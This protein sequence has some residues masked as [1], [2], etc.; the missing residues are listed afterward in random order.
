MERDL[1]TLAAEGRRLGSRRPRVYSEAWPNPRISSPPWVSELIALLGG[2]PAV[3]AGQRITDEQVAAARPDVIVLAWTATGGKADPRRAL[4]N[5]AWR[6]IPPVREGRVF[7]VRDELLNT[8]SPVLVRGAREL[9]RAIRDA[10]ER[11]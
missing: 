10:E 4:H 3:P 8:P 1:A 11:L 5:P 7:V 9:R 6:D 2:T